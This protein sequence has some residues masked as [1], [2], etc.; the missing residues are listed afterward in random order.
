V[1]V[2]QN[3]GL[4]MLN[5]KAESALGVFEQEGIIIM[6]H[7]L[8]HRSSVFPVSSKGPLH[9]DTSYDTD[10]DC[11]RS[12]ITKILMPSFKQW[13]H[14]HNTGEPGL[15]NLD[16]VLR[17]FGAP[18]NDKVCSPSLVMMTSP[19]KWKILKRDV[20]QLTVNNQSIK[21]ET[22]KG[23]IAHLSHM[24]QFFPCNHLQK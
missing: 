19:Y 6:P 23:Y 22:Y 15:Q 13:R 5:N 8:W 14:H 7:L 4:K 20:K 3:L 1:K 11:G 24:G 2:L 10:E 17:A 18:G 12:I 21:Q 16:S 9:S